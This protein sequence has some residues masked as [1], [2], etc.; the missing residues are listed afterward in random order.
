MTMEELFLRPLRP[1]LWAIIACGSRGRPPP[2]GWPNYY[3][4]MDQLGEAE[5]RIAKGKPLSRWQQQLVD[6][7]W[8]E[9]PEGA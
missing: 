3:D 7:A 6:V 9:M 1:E 4:L 8:R 2:G 5:W